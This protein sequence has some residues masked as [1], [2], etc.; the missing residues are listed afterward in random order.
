MNVNNGEEKEG[1]HPSIGKLQVERAPNQGF[2][3]FPSHT[4][5]ET[6]N[7]RIIDPDFVAGRTAG[8]SPKIVA[9][10]QFVISLEIPTSLV[11]VPPKKVTS[12]AA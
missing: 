11:R 6:T 12:S 5:E 1:L 7:D 3:A 8:L 9:M 2:P 10:I 4:K